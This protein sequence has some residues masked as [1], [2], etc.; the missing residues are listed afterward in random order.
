VQY[1]SGVPIAPMGGSL[2]IAQAAYSMGVLPLA[3][4]FVSLLPW[5][6]YLYV[7]GKR[8]KRA[9]EREKRAMQERF[10]AED[11]ALFGVKLGSPSI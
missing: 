7:E 6:P 2:L 5:A 3:L 4:P 10:E 8:R 11:V 1:P 9:A